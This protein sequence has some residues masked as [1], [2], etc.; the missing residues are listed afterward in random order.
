L[1]DLRT[2]YDLNDYYDFLEYLNLK[3]EAEY[4]ANKKERV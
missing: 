3:S 4:L 1:N 2:V